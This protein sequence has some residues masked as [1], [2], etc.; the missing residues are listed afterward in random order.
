MR[1]WRDLAVVK[2]ICALP[3]ASVPGTPFVAYLMNHAKATFRA[4][5]IAEA[6]KT[7]MW[8]NEPRGSTVD[9]VYDCELASLH[10]RR[11]RLEAQR[12]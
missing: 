11:T 10:K 7:C 8:G 6:G 5:I 4:T 3:I 9:T 12:G 2:D 1:W